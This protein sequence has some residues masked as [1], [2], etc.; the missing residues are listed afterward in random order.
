VSS[1]IFTPTHPTTAEILFVAGGSG[2]HV[3]TA[4]GVIDTFSPNL[5]EKTLFVGSTLSMEGEVQQTSMEQRLTAQARVPFVSIRSGKLQRSL[6][7]QSFRLLGGVFGGFIDSWKLFKTVKPKVVISFGGYVSVPVVLVAWFK[8][9]P[10]YLHEQTTS[11]GLAN[12]IASWV[13]KKICIS[14]P[15]SAR[16]FPAEKVILTGSPKRHYLFDPDTVEKTVPHEIRQHL[17]RIKLLSN[18]YPLLLVLGGSQG[19]HVINEA[20]EPLLGQL[21]QKYQ[22]VVQ[23]GSNQVYKDYDRLSAEAR[24]YPAHVQKRL[25]ITPFLN[26]EL[27][28]LYRL[29]SVAISRGGANV[30]YELG[31]SRIPSIIIPLPFAT[32]NEQFTNAQILEEQ[33]LGIILEEKNLNPTSLSEALEAI[34]QYQRPET[35]SEIFRTDAAETVRDLLIGELR[36]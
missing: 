8:K 19:S 28:V 7:G 30:V 21:L 32:Q 13:A 17:T 22:V 31:M 10:I 4:L 3:Q 33:G 5:K 24:T 36:A 27:A 29:A 23:T 15:Q 9:I 35:S 20:I 12:K 1:T 14:Y 26:E 18:E 11:L 25:W 34:R 2:G 6:S 16:F